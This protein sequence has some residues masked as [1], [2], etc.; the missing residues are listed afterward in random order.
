[1][2]F[3]YQLN[4]SIVFWV[5]FGAS[6]IGPIHEL[7]CSSPSWSTKARQRL[8][9]VEVSL[10]RSARVWIKIQWFQMFDRFHPRK[11]SLRTSRW[12]H[13]KNREKSKHPHFWTLCNPYETRT[14]LLF[15]YKE[16]WHSLPRKHPPD[17]LSLIVRRK[18][19]KNPKNLAW[20]VLKKKGGLAASF[21][22]PKN[23]HN[24]VLARLQSPP[25]KPSNSFCCSRKYRGSVAP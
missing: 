15:L 20:Y 2:S 10:Q 14:F 12:H 4:S 13:K 11:C 18:Y 9:L 16:S 3:H 25:L 23:Q 5:C 6:Y 21:F 1:M 7:A 8:M 24:Q 22:A 19:P 17:S